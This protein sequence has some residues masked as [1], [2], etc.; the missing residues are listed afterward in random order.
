MVV[1]VVFL[2]VFIMSTPFSKFLYAR[3]LRFPGHASP[4]KPLGQTSHTH[5][6]GK[7][8]LIQLI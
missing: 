3:Q 4:E 2:F 8:S 5:S 7:G 6:S 1:V